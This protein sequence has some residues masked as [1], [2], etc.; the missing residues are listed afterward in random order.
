[1]CIQWTSVIKYSVE[2]TRQPNPPI[3]QFRRQCNEFTSAWS[4]FPYNAIDN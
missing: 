1:M 2:I 4:M 3:S